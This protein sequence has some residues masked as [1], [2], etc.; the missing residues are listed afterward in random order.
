MVLN[1]YGHCLLPI[2][3]TERIGGWSLDCIEIIGSAMNCSLLHLDDFNGLLDITMTYGL[4]LKSKVWALVWAVQTI[5]GTSTISCIIIF[6][7]FFAVVL[8]EQFKSGVRC[9]HSKECLG[10][11]VG[12]LIKSSAHALIN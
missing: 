1:H 10:H 8:A 4:L 9:W 7:T 2:V 5:K 6:R 3:R 11:Y 12:K